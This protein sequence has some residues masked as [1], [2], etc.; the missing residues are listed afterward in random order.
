MGKHDR[1]DDVWVVIDDNVYN[2][3]KMVDTHPGGAEVIMQ[4]AGKLANK[5]FNKGNHPYHVLEHT[6]PK[7]KIGRI[8]HD[9]QIESWQRERKT[10]RMDCFCVVLLGLSLLSSLVYLSL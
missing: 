8:L 10:G 2:L 3:T 1:K 9:S 4:R 6:L 7:K 5:A